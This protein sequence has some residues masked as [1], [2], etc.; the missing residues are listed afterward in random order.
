[1]TGNST[2]KQDTSKTDT[3][4]I[5]DPSTAD[6]NTTKQIA[7]DSD[8]LLLPS[9]DTTPIE[10]QDASSA[11]GTKTFFVCK[12]CRRCSLKQYFSRKG[13]FSKSPTI[14]NDKV[15]FPYLDMSGLSEADKS[16]VEY[17]LETEAQE[18]IEQF[19]NFMSDVEDSLEEAKIPLG[20]VKSYILNLRA[21]TNNLGVKVLDEED[22]K[23]IKRAKTLSDIFIIL[24]EY[25]SFFNYHIIESIVGKYGSA[26]ARKMLQDYIQVFNNF[27]Q[28]S[29]FEV[30]EYIFSSD[31]TSRKMARVLVFKHTETG[32]DRI[33]EIKRMIG[34]VANIFQLQPSALQLCSIKKGCVELHFLISAAVVNCIFPV[35]P[36]QDSALS[37]IG[38]K[39]FSCDRTLNDESKVCICMRIMMKISCFFGGGDI[40]FQYALAD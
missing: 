18:I 5:T 32:D 14:P 29:I 23:E 3:L 39:V 12:Y 20:K 8:N 24:C 36:S 19:A 34:K 10:K 6:T 15:S 38:V 33:D 1:M 26:K 28:R 21:F 4:A 9:T 37:E 7:P 13:C 17:R 40:S 22:K 35:S 2:F 11:S 30:P 25:I 31:C 16:D 27:C